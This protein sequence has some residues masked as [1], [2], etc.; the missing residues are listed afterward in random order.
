MPI[1]CAAMPEALLE[2]ELFGHERGAFTGAVARKKGLLVEANGGTVFLDEIADLSPSLQAK[3]LRT[4]EERQ[5]RPVGSI[6]LV[7]TDIR[8]V[9]ATNVDLEAAVAA[10]RFRQ[11]LYYRLHVV[12]VALPPLRSREG[13][14]PLLMQAFLSEYGRIA[15]RDVL[16]VSPEAWAALEAYR[17]PG[18][19]RELRNLAQRLT[20]LDDDGRVTLA[21]LPEAIRGWKVPAGT[22]LDTPPPPYP[23]ARD[24]AL[25]DFRRAYVRRLLEQHAGNVSRAAAAA[26]VSRRT[27]H[28]W[29]AEDRGEA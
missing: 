7:T 24:G 6:A 13:D 26:G 3:L 5:V 8:V 2:S 18:N 19:V 14:V 21:D 12:Q 27:F 10:G 4:L 28:R 11:D 9:A 20:V 23:Q 16:R 1:D 17:W 25:T 22:D 29:L 15:K